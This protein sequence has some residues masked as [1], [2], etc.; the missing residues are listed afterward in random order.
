MGRNYKDFRGDKNPNY[1]TGLASSGKR[2]SLYNS[3]CNMKA[4]CLNKNNP[5]YPRYGGR[6]INICDEWLGI[7]GFN[8]WANNN[9]WEQGLSID[10]IDNDEG[11]YPDNCQWISQSSNS[12]KKSTTK[13]SLDDAKSIRIA[14]DKGVRVGD[15][16]N[17]YNVVSGTIWFIVKNFTHVADGECTNKLKERDVK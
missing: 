7:K 17:K 15:I 5:K 10:R 1:K 12:R 9:G 3:W 13:L 2:I 4:R 14:F 11:Y 16:A 6:G 8:D